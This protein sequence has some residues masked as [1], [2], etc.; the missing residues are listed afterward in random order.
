MSMFYCTACDAME[1][2]DFVGYEI[3]ETGEEV[4]SAARD[5]NPVIVPVNRPGP[6]RLGSLTNVTYEQIVAVFGEPNVM[7]DPDKVRYSWGF[8]VNG[9]FAAIWDYKGSYLY[10]SWSVYDPDKVIV[11][12]LYRPI[13]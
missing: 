8:T 10:D 13:R 6:Y 3:T 4:C 12:A 5:E 11:K 2:A 7:D 1:D 9:K